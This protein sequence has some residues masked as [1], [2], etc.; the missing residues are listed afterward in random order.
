MKNILLPRICPLLLLFCV[1]LCI[2]SISLSAVN[3][4]NHFLLKIKSDDVSNVSNNILDKKG[5]DAKKEQENV[6]KH[7][8][9]KGKGRMLLDRFMFDEYTWAADKPIPRQLKFQNSLFKRL[10]SG[11]YNPEVDLVSEFKKINP[12]F[13]FDSLKN[14][15]VNR[16]VNKELI[17]PNDTIFIID[18]FWM[19]AYLLELSWGVIYNDKALAKKAQ[20]EIFDVKRGYGLI[21][22]DYMDENTKH[23][24]NRISYSRS[25]SAMAI[26]LS[27]AL[28]RLNGSFLKSVQELPSK[29]YVYSPFAS[30]LELM[31]FA[32]GIEPKYQ[33]IISN[34]L[35][36]SNAKINK[37]NDFVK[38]IM[39]DV[40]YDDLNFRAVFLS[41]FWIGNITD[42]NNKYFKCLKSK[43]NASLFNH[44][45]GQFVTPQQQLDDWILRKTNG[46]IYN[47]FGNVDLPQNDTIVFINYFRFQG[48]WPNFAFNKNYSSFYSLS[49]TSIVNMLSA[50]QFADYYADNRYIML[51]IMKDRSFSLRLI[52]PT[53]EFSIPKLATLLCEDPFL[54]NA[55]W[56]KY[57]SQKRQSYPV[58]TYLNHV[59]FRIN[60]PEFSTG[61]C[62]FDLKKFIAK[63]I[64]D[65]TD[66][67]RIA[68]IFHASGFL[69]F[70]DVTF[71][72]EYH[73]NSHRPA[74]ITLD[75]QKGYYP[76]PPYQ[77]AD[78]SFDSP[79][80]FAIVHNRS[81]IPV[82]FGY[83][84][85]PTP[86]DSI[87]P[88][89][90]KISSEQL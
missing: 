67:V 89:Y 50:W 59:Y 85:N 34:Y 19:Y 15:K 53:K 39:E 6:S 21:P 81:G 61:L 2:V 60:V 7:N 9:I 36:L 52:K 13:D 73:F 24:N 22:L 64:L 41:S 55:N 83:I 86:A 3:S 58:G 27:E 4:D 57:Y 20:E 48:F 90:Q 31:M 29:N 43:Y 72:Q 75:Y 74:W 25:D 40:Q 77:E 32:N 54:F 84:Q 5:Q 33:K 68:K 70:T 49:N 30:A 14:S 1:G 10:Y 56:K 51:N 35:G 80:L 17:D 69:Q 76:H 66:S 46:D 82:L 47:I 37:I 62:S 16:L 12:H 63:H 28:W 71:N 87:E 8:I 45:P 79:F 23:S 26:G 18:N 42:I 11:F 44:W 88:Q 38:F 65:I 78:I